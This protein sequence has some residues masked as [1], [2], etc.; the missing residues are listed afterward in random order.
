MLR[1]FVAGV[2]LILGLGQ[3]MEAADVLVRP[4]YRSNGTYV[5][6]HYRSAPDSSRANNW[7]SYPNINPYTGRFGTRSYP[8][9]SSYGYGSYSFGSSTGFG[10]GG[11]GSYQGYGSYGGYGYRY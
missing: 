5:Y 3:A 11:Y 8:Y 2:V 7:S 10:A 1:H 9:Y 4:Y 6:Q